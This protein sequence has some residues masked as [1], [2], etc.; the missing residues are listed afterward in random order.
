MRC[1]DSLLLLTVLLTV[2]QYWSRPGKFKTDTRQIF[3][4]AAEGE[5]KSFADRPRVAPRKNS[6]QRTGLKKYIFQQ[7]IKI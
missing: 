4:A 7:N 5:K 3:L 2:S 6:Q 1:Q